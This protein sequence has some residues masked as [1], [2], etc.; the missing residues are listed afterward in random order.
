MWKKHLILK[1]K[2]AF[3]TCAN[4]VKPFVLLGSYW[5]CF[6]VIADQLTLY[7][8]ITLLLAAVYEGLNS[9]TSMLQVIKDHRLP[10]VQMNQVNQVNEINNVDNLVSL[11][12]AITTKR[13]KSHKSKN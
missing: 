7:P 6:R 9:S 12:I 8:S 1:I 2:L 4:R 10:Y 3:R 5:S 11:V 13:N